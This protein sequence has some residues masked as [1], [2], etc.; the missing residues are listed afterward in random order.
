MIGAVSLMPI[1][2]N[3]MRPK[4]VMNLDRVVILITKNLLKRNRLF[5]RIG[6]LSLKISERKK[7]NVVK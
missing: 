2:G 7:R 5:L 6:Y 1:D 4:P 3:V